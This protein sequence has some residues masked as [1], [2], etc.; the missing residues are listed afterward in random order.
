MYSSEGSKEADAGGERVG[1]RL[2]MTIRFVRRYKC[3]CLL[4]FS[5]YGFYRKVDSLV[6][7]S[8]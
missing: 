5:A 8:C 2:L 6:D 7:L 3:L 4:E 1:K